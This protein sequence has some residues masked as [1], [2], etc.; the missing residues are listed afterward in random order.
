MKSGNQSRLVYLFWV[1]LALGGLANA[2]LL[3]WWQ[4]TDLKVWAW[5]ASPFVAAG[6][7]FGRAMTASRFF[8]ALASTMTVAVFDGFG[9][10]SVMA[11]KFHD[12]M[13]SLGTVL[14]PAYNWG[15]V[16]L[17]FLVLF[18]QWCRSR[19]RRV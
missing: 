15:L 5:T 1:S 11:A 16:V 13:E 4:E 10:I 3:M 18:A 14:V 8:A 7:V 9:L 2:G 12:S 17:G 19:W 6:V